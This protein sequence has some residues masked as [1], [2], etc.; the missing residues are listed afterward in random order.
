[1]SDIKYWM[2][3]DQ[4]EGLGPVN[5]KIIYDAVTPIALSISD[6]FHL[7]SDEL[8]S[9]FNFSDKIISGFQNAQSLFDAVE[10]DYFKLIDAKISVIPFFSL[11][12]PKRILKNLASGYP[13]ILYGFGNLNLLNT[14]SIAVLGDKDISFKGEIISYNAAKS[15][16]NHGITS[17]SGFAKGVGTIVHRSSIENG[18]KTTAVLP[19]GI[20]NYKIPDSLSE[21][22]NPD[23]IA[24]V[25]PF[26]PNTQA[27]KFNAFHRNKIICAMSKAVYIVEAPI[28][29]GIFEAAKSA[30]K[31]NIPLF[32][33]KYSE[34]PQNALGNH[35]IIL[36]YKAEPIT[37]K[38]DIEQIEPDMDKI[39]AIAKFN[40]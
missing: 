14:D 18:G 28:E 2:A 12:Y 6:V 32:V 40:Q 37:R 36:D 7:S 8:K 9:E 39:I 30:H 10:E 33:T 35:K 11:D 5:L 16:A 24:I 21:I 22:I 29:G 31:L 17:I 27:N 4:A 19:Y 20:F 34:Y 3:L 23:S 13:S 15:L 25:S 26:Y 38:K 1:M